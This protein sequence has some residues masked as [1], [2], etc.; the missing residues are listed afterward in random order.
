[1]P[2]K[3]AFK[4]NINHKRPGVDHLLK[5]DHSLMSLSAT[6][7]IIDSRNLCDLPSVKVSTEIEIDM[8]C[9]SYSTLDKKNG[10][11]FLYKFIFPNKVVFFGFINL[12]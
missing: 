3:L 8:V 1:M 7:L 11:N 10:F 5:H 6:T 12:I 4:S 2:W 9:F